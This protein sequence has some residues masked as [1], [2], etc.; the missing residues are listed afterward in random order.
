MLF[1]LLKWALLVPIRLVFYFCYW[2]SGGPV[3]ERIELPIKHLPVKKLRIVHLSD[4][5]FDHQHCNDRNKRIKF[6]HLRRETISQ[7]IDD[8][9]QLQPDVVVI[10]GDFVH[11][12]ALPIHELCDQYLSRIS[13]PHV[14]AVL[15]NHDYHE[16]EQGKKLIVDALKSKTHIHLLEQDHNLCPIAKLFFNEKQQISVHLC[17]LDN[18]KTAVDNDTPHVEIMG[19]PDRFDPVYYTQY[20]ALRDYL[21]KRDQLRSTRNTRVL[22]VHNPDSTVHFLRDNWKFDLILA[23]HTHGG[24]VCFYL[25][26]FLSASYRS[27]D[28]SF[29]LESKEKWFIR[30]PVL[31]LVLRVFALLPSCLRTLLSKMR[32]VQRIQNVVKNWEWG[33]GLSCATTKDEKLGHRFIYTNRGLG[34]HAPFRICCPPEVTCLDLIQY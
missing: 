30:E 18:E 11:Q 31:P 10:T 12:S 26:W 34:T 8:V 14:F 16:K 22:L 13:C 2:L 15:G 19:L 24:Q 23:G 1:A 5:H 33:I 20:D 21:D 17:D 7:A 25:P 4:L 3:V 27:K 29:R 9:N 32:L 28:T 6:D